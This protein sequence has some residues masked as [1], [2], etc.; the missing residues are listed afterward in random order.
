MLESMEKKLL[1]QKIKTDRMVW[2]ASRYIRL[3][4]SL[5]FKEIT[6]EEFFWKLEALCNELK[7]WDAI[8]GYK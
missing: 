2:F 5:E 3:Q 6:Y 7:R 4:N 8:H 1:D